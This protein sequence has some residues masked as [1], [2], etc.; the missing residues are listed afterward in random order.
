MSEATIS[1][2]RLGAQDSLETPR[3]QDVSVSAMRVN[4]E[5]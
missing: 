4:P 3:V 2:K 5:W 1:D